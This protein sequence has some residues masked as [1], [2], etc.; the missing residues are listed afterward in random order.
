M[1]A[2]TMALRPPAALG[3]TLGRAR[4]PQPAAVERMQRSLQQQGQLT[5][6]VTVRR[7][8]QLELVDGFKRRAAATALGWP[9]LLC[10]VVTLDETGQWVAMLQLNL[11]GHSITVLEEALVLRELVSRGLTQVDIG[12]LLG[13]HKAWV[14]RRI[15]LTERLHPE[16][17]EQ[18]R[19]GLLHPGVARRLLGLPAGNQL[20]LAAVAMARTLGPEQTEHLVSLWQRAHAQPEVRRY[21]LT[22]PH[23]A[24]AQAYPKPAPTPCDPRL[25]P[26]SQTLL[27]LLRLLEDVTPRL[28]RL[29]RPP[30]ATTDLTILRPHL[31]TTQTL[32]HELATALGLCASAASAAA[33][34][35]STAAP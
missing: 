2:A 8:D 1:S 16:L 22:H 3:T 19:Q 25:T 7:G 27:R 18:M 24:L 14:S 21:L 6:V 32:A 15:G 26:P 10:R 33:S 20:E 4:C 5:P 13:R 28:L 9:E 12:A 34:A 31:Q 11:A 29:L 17:I 30:P 35:A 23:Q